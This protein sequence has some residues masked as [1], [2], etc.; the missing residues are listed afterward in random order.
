MI[1]DFTINGQ[2]LLKISNPCLANDTQEYLSLS[3]SFDEDWD[4]YTHKYCIFTYKGKHY[5]T[6]LEYDNE[7]EAYLQIVP[8]EV[9]RGKGFYITLYGTLGE[10]RITTNQIRIDLLESGYTT[11][12]SSIRYPNV[13]DIFEKIRMDEEEYADNQ[14]KRG[15]NTLYLKIRGG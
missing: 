13:P 10:E 5:E 4:N 11:D 2:I 1:L 3:F 9:L 14:V 6:E 7:Q 8:K 12:I 15:L